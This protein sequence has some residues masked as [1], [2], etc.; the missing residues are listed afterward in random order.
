MQASVQTINLGNVNT[1]GKHDCSLDVQQAVQVLIYPGQ[2]IVRSE[3]NSG[4]SL[5]C[6]GR[7]MHRHQFSAKKT[8]K[9]FVERSVTSSG[10]IN[11]RPEDCETFTFACSRRTFPAVVA[12]H[13]KKS[14]K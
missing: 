8:T 13:I 7:Q 2:N 14:R 9:A 1:E 6:N 10:S 11:T 4:H 12:P 5:K 3:R